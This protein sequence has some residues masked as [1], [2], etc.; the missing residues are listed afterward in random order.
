MEVGAELRNPA[1]REW[2][3]AMAET[4]VLLGGVAGLI[5]PATFQTGIACIKEIAID[6]EICKRENLDELI[7]IWTSPCTAASVI[8]NRNTPLHRDNGATYGSMDFLTSV[9][10]FQHG[11]F[12]TPSLGCKF[13]FKSGTMIGLLG[14]MVPHAAEVE[15]ERLCYAQYLR[16]VILTPLGVA[17]PDFVNIQKLTGI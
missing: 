3:T 13:L 16:E 1:G 2:V 10:E 8:N 14:R 5:H 11:I 4:N 6:G 7:D 9:G 17:G 15:G 12:E